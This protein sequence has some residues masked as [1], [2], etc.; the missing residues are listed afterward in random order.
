MPLP[1][2][3][4]AKALLP[5]LISSLP[6]L[7]KLFGSG[8]EVS[9]RNLAT[10][11]TVLDIVQGATKAV[12]AQEA[13]EKV[14]NDP[15]ARQAAESAIEARWFELAEAGGGGIDGARKADA[16]SLSGDGPWWGFIRSPSFL[17]MLVLTPLVYLIVLSMIGII[18][19]VQWSDEVRSQTAGFLTGTIVGGLMGYYFGQTT[20]RNRTPVP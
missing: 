2:L 13:V 10:V 12:N 11:G 6:K 1:I 18:G 9:E 7:G 17:V 4:I 5:E 3:G 19:P 15:A 16:V 14:K 20:S 8:S